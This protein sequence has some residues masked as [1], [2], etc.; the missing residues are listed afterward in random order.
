M[1]NG[2][3]SQ[4]KSRQLFESARQ[5]MPGG[6]SRNTIYREPNPD[7]AAFGQGCFVTDIDGVQRI[8]LANNMASLI[9][10]H[11]HPQVVAAVTEQLQRGTAVTMATEAEFELAQ[12]LCNRVPWFDKIRFMNSGTE[13]V[14]AA[15]KAARAITGRPKIAKAEGTYHGTYDFAEVSQNASP[16]NWGDVE[17]PASVPVARAAFPIATLSSPK[18]PPLYPA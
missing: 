8:D 15:I 7:Y 4:S 2:P 18:F 16:E 13:A 5:I 3:T 10:G 12:L 9:H 14:M 17:H 6:L 11:A 1:T